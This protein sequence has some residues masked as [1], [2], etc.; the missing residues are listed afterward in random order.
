MKNTTNL[1]ALKLNTHS[2]YHSNDNRIVCALNLMLFAEKQFQSS[3]VIKNLEKLKVISENCSIGKNPQRE[4]VSDFVDNGLIDAIKI[5]I[6]FENYSKAILLAK[7]YL[8]H[9][10]DSNKYKEKAKQQKKAPILIEKF[11]VDFYDNTSINSENSQLRKKIRGL[12]DTTGQYSVILNN[13]AYLDIIMLDE[14]LVETLIELN[15]ARNMLHL[16]FSLSFNMNSSTYENFK[17]LTEF[18]EVKMKERRK[19]LSDYLFGEGNTPELTFE[20]KST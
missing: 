14:N 1:D 2:I 13:K 20:I 16:Q 6:C 9:N 11:P 10:I 4:I 8:I 5:S 12:K 15:K 18:V 17:L 7:G 19:K 3:F